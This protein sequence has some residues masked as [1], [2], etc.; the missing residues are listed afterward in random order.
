MN[1]KSKGELFLND[2]LPLWKTWRTLR[3]NQ[4][5]VVW[6]EPLWSI[7]YQVLLPYVSIYMSMIGLRSEQ[8]GMLSSFGLAMQFVW[9]IFS[10]AIIDKYGRRKTMLLFGVLSWTVSCLLFAVAKDYLIVM[11]AVLFNSMW[12]VTGNCFSCILVEDGD[13][14]HLVSIWTLINLTGLVAGFFSPITGLFIDKFTFMPTLRTVYFVAMVM[15]TARFVLQYLY[16]YES[17][18]GLQRREACSNQTVIS[19]TFRDWRILVA[20]LR[21]P[22]LLLCVAFMALLTSFSTV[23]TTFWSLFV[24][25]TF[26]VSTA[27]LSVFPVIAS[28][29]TLVVY[30]FITPRISLRFVR[31]PLLLGLSFHLSSIVV[32]L[33]GESFHNYWI[34]IVLLSAF[35]EALAIAL[36]GPLTESIMA[37]VIRSDERARLNSFITALILLISTPMGWLAGSLFQANPT[38]TMVFNAGLMVVAILLSFFVVRRLRPFRPT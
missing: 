19:L 13:S 32:L 36:L 23:Q 29:T 5:T 31:Y 37:V 14:D 10:G 22:R 38:Y 28:V 1:R 18:I 34:G 33:L 35:C 30:L 26:Y 3:G 7:P 20:E 11:L 8:I 25:K 12:Q 16:S 9:A 4:R 2:K 27:T 17:S 6:V 15:M 24:T 21:Q